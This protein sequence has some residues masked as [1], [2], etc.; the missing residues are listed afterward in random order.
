MQLI[1]RYLYINQILLTANDS[2]FVVEYR[3]V[4]TRTI[5]VYKGID[6][7]IQFKLINADQKP[8]RV[9]GIPIIVVFDEEKNKILEKVCAVLDDASSTATKGLFEFTFTENDLLNIKQQYLNY[10]VYFENNNGTR[11]LTYSNRNFDSSGVIY[12]DGT[13]YPGPKNSVKIENFYPVGDEWHA[14]SDDTDRIE[15]HP[16]L[17]GNEALHTVAIYSSNYVGSVKI[18]AT[19]DNQIDMQNNWSTVDT[20]VFNGQETE[21]VARNLTGVYRYIRFVATADPA[22]K[23]TQI[24]VRN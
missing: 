15:A 5:K 8:V 13:A 17:N 16:G 18:E 2:G 1:P 11:N 6:N 14:G 12:L 7:T 9:T 3:P 4:Y 22:D 24:L 10:N 23:L 19:L 21:P 20:V